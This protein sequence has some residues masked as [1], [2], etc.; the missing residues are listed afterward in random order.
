MKKI[1]YTIEMLDKK[2]NGFCD[3][4]NEYENLTEVKSKF[5]EIVNRIKAEKRPVVRQVFV[6]R[7]YVNNEGDIIDSQPVIDLQ[8]EKK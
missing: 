5:Y 3:N 6:L 1:I 4:E 7:N 8:Y 2:G